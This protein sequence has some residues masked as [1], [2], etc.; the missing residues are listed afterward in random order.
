MET[1]GIRECRDSDMAVVA[2]IYSH[3]V[4]QGLGTFEYTP[5]SENEMRERRE[6][7]CAQGFPYF[8][9]ESERGVEGYACAGPWRPRP[10]YRFSCEDSVYVTPDAARKGMGRALL[11]RVIAQSEEAGY[12]L[13]IAVIGDSGNAAS[14]GL[15]TSLGFTHAGVLPAVGWK[16]ERWVDTVFMTRTLGAGSNTPPA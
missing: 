7:L 5:P 10:G 11:T 8:V 6:K 2:R 9:A 13:M 15:H 4:E 3:W 14:I 16:H 12:R 1:Q